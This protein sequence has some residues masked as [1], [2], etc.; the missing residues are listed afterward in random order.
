MVAAADGTELLE[1][2]Y[3]PAAD[4][5]RINQ[6]ARREK[7]DGFA[8]DPKTGEWTRHSD[9]EPDNDE[10]E[11]T[12]P[13]VITGIKTFVTDARN[14]LL[15]RPLGE[16]RDDGFLYSLLYSL[17]RG[18]QFTYQVEEQEVAAE[19]VGKAEHTRLLLWEAAE[20]GTG[21]W[22][23]LLEDG[24]GFAQVAREALRL[25]HVDPESGEE[26]SDSGEP[27]AT[28]CYEC[29]L[30]YSNQ[31]V[32][33]HLDRH[34]VQSFLLDLATSTATL[35][36]AGRPYDDQYAWLLQHLDPA[37]TF[38]RQFV[39]YLYQRKLRLPD[40]A[41]NRPS[42]ELFVQPDFYYNRDGQRPVCVF[43]DGPAH[44]AA[45]QDAH[46]RAS[47]EALE[48]AGYRVVVIGFGQP[49]DEQVAAHQDVFGLPTRSE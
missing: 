37:S 29:L 17:Q 34:R 43:V 12:T 13:H 44:A 47:R 15:L 40:D 21:V 23:R 49:L 8:I 27:C 19:L 11:P 24:G 7:A 6:K 39:D 9:D 46:D 14:L 16:A 28:A 3:A 26:L 2:T 25:S 45:R 31:R 42:P 4:L 33:R 38:E 18:I 48:D 41:Q 30:S 20:G 1:V 5:W 32:H 35:Q 10:L 36:T 22:E